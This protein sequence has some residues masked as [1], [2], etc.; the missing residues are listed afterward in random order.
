MTKI[1]LIRAVVALAILLMHSTAHSDDCDYGQPFQDWSFEG[2]DLFVCTFGS[3]RKEAAEATWTG[4][5]I[6]VRFR[7]NDKTEIL[8]MWSEAQPDITFSYTP[9]RLHV[10]TR[11]WGTKLNHNTAF[12]STTYNLEAGSIRTESRLLATPTEYDESKTDRLAELIV[13]SY[14]QPESYE[15]VLD[16]MYLL[17]DM[18]LDEPDIVISRLNRIKPKIATAAALSE[19]LSSIVGEL[20]QVRSLAE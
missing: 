20:E 7:S 13:E 14:L 1:P 3:V 8:G 2:I 5:G 6:E 9:G 15:D 17:R 12:M 10:I 4:S 11:M 16:A 18:G 19:Y